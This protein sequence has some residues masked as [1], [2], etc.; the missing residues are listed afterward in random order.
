MK[1]L[2]YLFLTLFA[3]VGCDNKDE[4]DRIVSNN[5]EASELPQTLHATIVNEEEAQDTLQS[6]T[7]LNDKKK[8]VWH[9]GDEI[10]FFVNNTH[11]R[12]KSAGQDG[13]E[14]VTFDRVS[15]TTVSVANPPLYSLAVYPYDETITCERENN[16]DKLHV[17]YPATQTYA[18]NSFAKG[19]NLMVSAGT[20]PNGA[21]NNLRFRN[22]CGYLVLKLYGHNTKVKTVT[23]SSR[24]GNEKISGAGTI[25]AKSNA[26][27]VTTM[28]DDASPTV[29]LNCGDQGVALGADA[30]HATEFWF[31]LPPV[32]FEGGIKVVVTDVNGITYTKE[33]TN[34]ITVA[35]N[36][37]KPMAP[38]QFVASNKIWYTKVAN[39]GS[40]LLAFYNGMNNPFD[41]DII[42][43]QYDP[44]VGKYF[45]RFNSPVKT[46]KENAFKGTAL[47]AI[48]LPDGLQTIEKGAFSET[49]LAAITIPGSVETIKTEAF[50][51]CRQLET[52]EFLPSSTQKPLAIACR[53]YSGA[54][55]G[56]FQISYFKSINL[57]RNLVYVK[58]NGDSFV[59]DEVDEGIFYN[60]NFAASISVTIGGQVRTIPDYLFS[61]LKITHLTIPGTVT[62]IG[63][64]VFNECTALTSLTFEPSPTG[65]ALTLGYNTEGEE[66]GPFLDSPLTTVNLNREIIYTLE[67][68]DLDYDD[69]G[70]FS[71]RPLTGGV[72]FGEQVRTLSPYMFSNSG[73]TSLTIPNTL[74]TIKAYTFDNCESLGTVNIEDGTNPLI[75]EY[76]APFINSPL[77][78]VHLGRE[79]KAKGGSDYKPGSQYSG[80]LYNKTPYADIDEVIVTISDHVQTIYPYT[81]SYLKLK[82][83]TIPASVTLIRA[84]AFTDCTYLN[85][86]VFEESSTP[87]QISCMHTAQINQGPFHDTS[88]TSITLGREISYCNDGSGG[89]VDFVPTA[90]DQGLFSCEYDAES[91]SVTLSNNVQT[92]SNYMFTGTNIESITIPGSVTT[93]GNGAFGSCF[94]L[95]SI[96]FEGSA[97]PLTIGF[98]PGPLEVGPFYDSPLTS[99]YVNRELVASQ[100][101]AAARNQADEGIF[102][103]KSNSRNV[104]VT[105]QG[106]VNTISDYMFSGVNMKTIW[107]PREVTTIGKKAFYDCS[108]L[109]GVTLA[110]TAPP[111]LN[112]NAFEGTLIDDKDLK[113]RWIALEYGSNNDILQAFKSATNWSKYAGIIQPQK[114]TNP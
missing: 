5:P 38:F 30:A 41:A 24:T 58:P 114:I 56:P 74:E 71:G 89:L 67:N 57:N 109:Y 110:H 75:I 15:E 80:L 13:E 95:A 73:I 96:R 60:T 111:I 47:Q 9:K 23:L 35:R 87:L 2:F 113:Y 4:F 98:Q 63:N 6:R 3:L 94:K 104:T 31:M 92:I 25:V 52:I 112:E 26:V 68:I 45:I 107:I 81:F 42:E 16:Q 29:S 53:E 77:T 64:D 19:T 70:I 90:T 105:L 88:L 43:H 51:S 20:I 10:S 33:T 106:N 21:D 27:P 61:G 44:S 86:I 40:G 108:Q 37:I 65:E 62:T 8:V 7:Y 50:Y 82:S 22:A 14:H 69:E 79:V 46:I 49:Q 102:S 18:A 99:I 76:Y 39:S 55:Y 1:K 97:T 28:G 91:L 11:G 59:P 78:N 66:D 32:T 83:I 100:E 93:I 54:E 103:T 85:T 34:A 12:Y 84:N 101:Y 36:S 72:I 48:D 17:T